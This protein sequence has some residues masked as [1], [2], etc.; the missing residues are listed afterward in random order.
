MLYPPLPQRI[1]MCIAS[2]YMAFCQTAQMMWV[3]CNLGAVA[4]AFEEM[5]TPY[6]SGREICVQKVGNAYQW[7][8]IEKRMTNFKSTS[9]RSKMFCANDA[10]FPFTYSCMF[11]D[12]LRH[13]LFE[14]CWDRVP[15]FLR[16]LYASLPRLCVQL[17]FYAYYTQKF[18]LTGPLTWCTLPFWPGSLLLRVVSAES[19]T[20]SVV[21]L[22]QWASCLDV[23]MW[24]FFQE[25]QPAAWP[26]DRQRIV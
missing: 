3:L 13:V 18:A 22:P 12:R 25:L 5:H 7:K 10:R 19:Q 26:I 21:P 9:Q 8:E 23:Q 20:D 2:G 6:A 16:T 24:G 17:D 11:R 14:T 1:L 4:L 15:F